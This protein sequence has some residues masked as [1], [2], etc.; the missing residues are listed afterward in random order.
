KDDTEFIGSEDATAGETTMAIRGKLL[1][2]QTGAVE[3][4]HGWLT[5]LA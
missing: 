3:D 5:R 1:G 4:T 2:I